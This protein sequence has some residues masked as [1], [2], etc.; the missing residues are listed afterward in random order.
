MTF[1]KKNSNPSNWLVVPIL[2]ARLGRSQHQ[3]VIFPSTL[4]AV[5]ELIH[6]KEYDHRLYPCPSVHFERR[7]NVF[8]FVSEPPSLPLVFQSKS[9][10]RDWLMAHFRSAEAQNYWP[11]NSTFL[12]HNFWVLCKSSEHFSVMSTNTASIFERGRRK[13]QR[14]QTVESLEGDKPSEPALLF[15]DMQHRGEMTAREGEKTQWQDCGLS[16]CI[17]LIWM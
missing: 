13:S 7:N 5:L 14:P 9:T 8:S 1:S 3:F 12:Q 6:N 4:Q 10:Q 17:N 16:S 15:W 2:R 11:P